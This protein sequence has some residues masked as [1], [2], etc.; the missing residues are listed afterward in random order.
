[1]T[2]EEYLEFERQTLEKHEFMDGQ[3]FQ[4]TP[5]TLRHAVISVSTNAAISGKTEANCF[6]SCLRVLV[7]PER[8][9]AY[10]DMS[11]VV[12]KVATNAAN[13]VLLN[14]TFLLEVVSPRTVEHDRDFKAFLYREMPSLREFLLIDEMSVFVDRYTRQ[15]DRSWIIT[16][17]QNLEDV[18]WLQSLDCSVTVS[19]FYRKAAKL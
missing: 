2:I 10:P 15:A 7:V 4:L 11:A 14:P 17:F 3:L 6:A 12:G 18:I 13:D 9:I 8:F 19:E 16:N 1:M 5:S